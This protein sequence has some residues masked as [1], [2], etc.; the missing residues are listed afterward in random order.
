MPDKKEEYVKVCPNCGST[1]IRIGQ[2]STRKITDAFGIDSEF[3]CGNCGFSSYLFPEVPL[4]KL[5]E[6]EGNL[7]E[8]SSDEVEG[9]EHTGFDKKAFA[10]SILVVSFSITI[11]STLAGFT[12]PLYSSIGYFAFL[13]IILY[14]LYTG[15][16]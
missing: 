16:F 3:K 9:Q 4:S 14:L 7:E 11:S 13:A 2:E 6:Y 15:K 12:D 1:D 10:A 8:I 5:E